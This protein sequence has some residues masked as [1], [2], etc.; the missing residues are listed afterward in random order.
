MT[1]K[2]KTYLFAIVAALFSAVPLCRAQ[3]GFDTDRAVSDLLDEGFM[4]L[5]AVDDSSALVISLENDAYKLQ[6]S[7]FAKALEVIERQ[8]LPTDKPTE[9]IATKLGVP[10]V[11]IK[12]DPETGEWRTSSRVKNWKTVRREKPVNSSFG[13][14]DLVMYPQVSLMN[15][16]ITQVYQSLWQISP[17]LEVSLWPGA[18]FSYQI[19]IPLFNDGYGYYENKVHPGL[20]TVSQSFRD[21][22]N[23]NITGRLSAGIF[24]ASRFGAALN[25]KYSF[26]DER[27]WVDG[28]LLYLLGAYY[29]DGFRMHYDT[30]NEFRWYFSANYYWP[31]AKTQFILRGQRFVLGDYGVKFEMIRHFRYCSI[32]MYAEKSKYGKTNGGFRF[33]VSLP[34]YRMK[35]KGYWPRIT[36]GQMGMSYN[37]NN[38]QYYYRECKVEAGDSFMEA[39]SFNPRYIDSEIKALKK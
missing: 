39:N 2:S 4:N 24:G 18:K 25:L 31:R 15:L 20:V 32:G 36:T 9:V 26:P 14:V 12:Y 19:Q 22:W 37:A 33:Q 11:T 16:I 1:V 7:G 17:S 29:M 21:P 28:Q 35:R 3:S 34:P 8:E 10:Q 30:E 6:A 5:R 13:K 23:L 27:F 38:E